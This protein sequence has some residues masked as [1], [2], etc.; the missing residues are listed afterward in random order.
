MVEGVDGSDERM[1]RL[2][3]YLDLYL[4][5]CVYL[6]LYLHMKLK[7]LLVGVNQ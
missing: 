2:N 6:Y 3:L 7:W 1:R 5:L 4:S